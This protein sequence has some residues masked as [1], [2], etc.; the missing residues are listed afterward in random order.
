MKTKKSNQQGQIY[1]TSS[2]VRNEQLQQVIIIS[3]AVNNLIST[4]K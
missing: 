2:N 1:Y 3:D 4:E